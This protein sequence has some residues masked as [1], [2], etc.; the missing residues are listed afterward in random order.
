MIQITTIFIHL[1]LIHTERQNC[2]LIGIVTLRL[3]LLEM[4]SHPHLAGLE[5]INN[6]N[7]A[8]LFCQLAFVNKKKKLEQCP[9]SQHKLSQGLLYLARS[10]QQ[11]LWSHATLTKI[12]YMGYYQPQIQKNVE[13]Y[14][15]KCKVYQHYMS[16]YHI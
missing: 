7:V 9:F 10:T 2:L 1:H 16:L 6:N 12:L 5:I 11:T 3:L 14:V 13:R 4:S 8:N 15:N